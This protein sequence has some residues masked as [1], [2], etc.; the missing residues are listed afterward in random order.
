[1]ALVLNEHP[2][3]DQWRNW[4]LSETADAYVL[5]AHAALRQTLFVI[6]KETLRIRYCAISNRWWTRWTMIPD[7]QHEQVLR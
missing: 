4:K 5:L 6:D 1:M 3:L 2:R 7:D